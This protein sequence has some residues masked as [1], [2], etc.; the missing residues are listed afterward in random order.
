M[1]PLEIH[2]VVCVGGY[3]KG[4][5]GVEYIG[6]HIV[7]ALYQVPEELRI[8]YC[9]SIHDDEFHDM[10]D[11]DCLYLYPRS[12]FDYDLNDRIEEKVRRDN[13]KM[14]KQLRKLKKILS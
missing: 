10:K 11:F 8:V 9:S 2:A 4:K 1:Q 12:D 6:P 5:R 7:R 13:K 14:K 3:V